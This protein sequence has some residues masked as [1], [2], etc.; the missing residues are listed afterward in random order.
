MTCEVMGATPE[1]WL[2]LKPPDVQAHMDLGVRTRLKT[3][4]ND[5][6]YTRVGGRIPQ[7]MGDFG[8]VA[9]ELGLGCA[10]H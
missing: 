5:V 9:V 1:P 7:G 2:R 6:E 10:V 3:T 4:Q 8:R